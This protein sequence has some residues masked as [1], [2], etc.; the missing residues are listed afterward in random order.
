MKLVI[1]LFSALFISACA[2]NLTFTKYTPKPDEKTAE[3]TLVALDK[4]R[5][6]D[7]IK[8]SIVSQPTCK[9]KTN[10]AELADVG[11]NSILS[12]KEDTY[13]DTRRAP[14]GKLINLYFYNH[15]ESSAYTTRCRGFAAFEFEP[16]KSY[17]MKVNNWSTPE[18]SHGGFGCMFNVYEADSNGSTVKLLEKQTPVMPNCPET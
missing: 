9:D 5:N 13:K 10:Y 15:S 11:T 2:S 17:I 16:N 8:V 3:F 4:Y 1:V 12:G 14:A 7:G 18:S 6:N